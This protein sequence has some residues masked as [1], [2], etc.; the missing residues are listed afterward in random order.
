MEVQAHLLD[1]QTKDVTIETSNPLFARQCTSTFKVKGVQICTPLINN[2]E[3][4]NRST[5]NN[6][7]TF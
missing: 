1:G 3:G 5:N 6:T 4:P 2:I 7:Q